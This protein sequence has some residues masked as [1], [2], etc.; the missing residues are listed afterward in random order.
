M[1]QADDILF[2]TVDSLPSLDKEKAAK[3]ILAL[4]ES[5]SWW[6]TY[7]GVKMIPLMTKNG[8]S[9]KEGSSNS[10]QGEFSW[11]EYAPKT[12]TD[13]FD[14]YAFAWLGSKSRVMALITLPGVSMQPHVDCNRN[15]LNTM[16]HKFRIVL[17]G[18]T[19]TLYW[20]TDKGI[21]NAPDTD[22]PFIMDGGW[23]H[24]MENT[25]DEI[26]VTIALGAP[27][28]GKTD[29]N[30]DITLIQNRNDFVMPNDMDHL[31]RDNR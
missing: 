3:E 25:T 11:T 22:K 4:P 21:V 19:S 23:P 30:G 2:A 1:K 18:K 9:A 31:F 16:Q 15:E 12:L 20:L 13:W 26:K 6:D 7:R 24:S 27:W 17:Q 28:N 29:Y 10:R 5:Y 14:D 8:M